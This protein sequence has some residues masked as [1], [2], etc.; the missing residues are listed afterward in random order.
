MRIRRSRA[1][2]CKAGKKHGATKCSEPIESNS[3]FEF[4]GK[5]SGVK[6]EDAGGIA[7]VLIRASGGFER[8]NGIREIE[9][10]KI[11]AIE[12]TVERE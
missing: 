4:A 7:I 5:V 12:R 2:C 6:V 10:K 3:Q 11:E 9:R 8:T 1:A